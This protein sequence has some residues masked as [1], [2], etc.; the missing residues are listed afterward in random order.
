MTVAI[1]ARAS[2]Q[3]GETP[4]V[5]RRLS[6]EQRR[7][8]PDG[9]ARRGLLLSRTP[10]AGDVLCQGCSS[11]RP[12][13]QWSCSND[14]IPRGSR[15]SAGYP[16]RHRQDGGVPR[17]IQAE[18]WNRWTGLLRQLQSPFLTFV[19]LKGR[20]LISGVRPQC[21]CSL[22]LE[23]RRQEG[24]VGHGPWSRRARCT[25]LSGVTCLSGRA[26]RWTQEYRP[27]A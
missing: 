12:N 25:G 26:A 2:S 27:A 20:P 13:C 22:R 24:R 5:P 9:W 16:G 21:Y 19:P 6:A 4:D 17:R 11:L 7:K 3:R 1:E 18:E 8:Y 15:G 23:V 14:A 10:T